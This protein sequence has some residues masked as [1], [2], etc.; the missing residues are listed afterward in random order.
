[1]VNVENRQFLRE[2]CKFLLVIWIKWKWPVCSITLLYSRTFYSLFLPFF[3]LEIFRFKYDKVFVRYSAYINFQI[4]II[5]TAM[6]LLH[7]CKVLEFQLLP[8]NFLLP[9]F[10]SMKMCQVLSSH[11]SSAVAS[12]FNHSWLMLVTF[13]GSTYIHTI[14]NGVPWMLTEVA[15]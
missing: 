12:S 14:K 3:V 5:W 13:R 11:C 4:R 6:V 1:M 10:V 9:R 15:S 7:L 8:S 2:N